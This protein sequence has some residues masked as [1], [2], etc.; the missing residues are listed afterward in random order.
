M[1]VLENNLAAIRRKGG[2]DLLGEAGCG[3]VTIEAGRKGEP[4]FKYNG[5]Y[6]H[7]LYEPLKEAE[8]QADEILSKKPDWVL[9]FGAGCGY[10]LKALIGKGHERII[11]LDVP[12]IL[13][14]VLKSVDLSEWLSKDTVFLCSDMNS[15]TEKVRNF[16]DGFDNLLCYSTT[17][18]RVSFPERLLEF[19]NRVHNAHTTNKVGIRTDIDS[20]MSW[21]ENYFDNL[22]SLPLHPPIDSLKGR[23][24]DVP[25]VIAGAGP[26]LKKNAHLLREFKGKALIFAAIT[27]YKPLLNYGVVPD[28]II[29]SEKVDLPEYFTF[30]E[31]DRK[32]RLVLAEV[33]HPGMFGRDVKGKFVFYNPY[34]GLSVAQ[35]KHWGSSYFPAIGGSVTT[36]ALDI[37]IM[38]GCDPIVFVGQDLCFGD[39]ETHA[40]GGVYVAQNVRIDRE[41]GEVVIEEDY[42]TLKDKAVSRFPLQ[43][44]KGQSGRPVPSKFDWATFHQWFEN[45]MANLRKEGSPVKVIN[46]TEGGAYIE[47]MEH[48]TLKSVLER[49]VKGA[50]DID[51]V[52]E[53]ALKD[54]KRVDFRGL[55]DSFQSMRKGLEN[56]RKGSRE[57]LRET[58]RIR[59][60]LDKKGLSPG[61]SRNAERIKTAE[62]K[63]FE[64]S[65]PALFI[66]ESLVSNTYGLKE[67]L[68]NSDEG[69][70]VEDRFRKDL[71]AIECSYRKV[72][73]MCAEF[74]PRVEAA[75]E[76]IQAEKEKNC[77]AGDPEN[78]C[79]D[80]KCKKE[81]ANA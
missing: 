17:P 34:V 33:S 8:A 27:A 16:T 29:A 3:A 22:R 60:G 57:I 43:W 75:I 63:I 68:K 4:T 28:F 55:L 44:L 11:A 54:R 47:G 59:K 2:T 5:K 13:N 77:R 58:A 46:A 51:A 23:F 48:A 81:A 25:M 70:S 1:G 50:F 15:V 67:Y 69:I 38:F 74:M 18:Y 32:T 37:G 45:Y 65:G 80:C 49:Y 62:E 9:L 64:S 61:L 12:E 7:S 66:W 35:A 24:K 26:S 20:R 19:T 21:I 71:D 72:G 14:S 76:F 10:L 73:E 40:P 36:A 31:P 56:I 39:N 30:G 52:M 78:P 6:F 41:K 53:G 79:V 42:V